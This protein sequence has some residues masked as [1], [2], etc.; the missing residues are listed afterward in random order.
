MF[1]IDVKGF[2]KLAE[3]RG[4]FAIITELVANAW[5]SYDEPYPDDA[6]VEITL[7]HEGEGKALLIAA[8][9]GHGFQDI[10]EAFTL[11]APSRRADKPEK[12][13]RFNIGEKSALSQMIC[14]S[15]IS[16]TPSG[17]RWDENKERHWVRERREKGTIVRGHIRISQIDYADVCDLYVGL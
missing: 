8:D 3:R 5:D 6:K 2:A 13:G 4:P 17:V 11:F 15:V 1:E 12:R 7:K 14:P 9:E 16:T 10:T